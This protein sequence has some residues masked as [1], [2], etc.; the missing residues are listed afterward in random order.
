MGAAFAVKLDLDYKG[1]N[2]VSNLNFHRVH[3]CKMQGQAH[4]DTHTHRP[5]RDVAVA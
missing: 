2:S 5:T 1:V 4:T 3:H